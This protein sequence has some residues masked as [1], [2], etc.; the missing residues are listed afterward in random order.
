MFVKV[1]AMA[2][3]LGALKRGGT[4]SVDG[5]KIHA[6]ASKHSAVSYKRAGEMIEYLQLEANRRAGLRGY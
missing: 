1:L 6:H 5:T 4:V 3:E 2:A